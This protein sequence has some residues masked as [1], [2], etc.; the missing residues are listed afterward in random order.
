MASNAFRQRAIVDSFMETSFEKKNCNSSTNFLV[1]L[2]VSNFGRHVFEID[3]VKAWKAVLK[4]VTSYALG[5]FMISKAPWY[6]LPFAWAW[7]GTAATGVSSLCIF[8]LH[9]LN[10]VSF[11]NML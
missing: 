6:L 4:T 11:A 9:T 8:S 5:L 7:T 2:S 1:L 3:N 10:L